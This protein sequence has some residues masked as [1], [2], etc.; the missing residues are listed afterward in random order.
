M[1][2]QRK[3]NRFIFYLPST[4]NVQP[5]SGK[6][7]S[8]Q[9]VFALEDKHL[10]KKCHPPPLSLSVSLLS[11]VSEGMEYSFGQLRSTVLAMSPS[12]LLPTPSILAFGVGMERHP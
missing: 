2:K 1:R 9:A 7:G 5:L 3:Q 11:K 10:T 8:I 6:Q 12:T 4:G